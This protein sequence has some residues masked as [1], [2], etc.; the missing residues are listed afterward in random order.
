MLRVAL[1]RLYLC[2]VLVVGS[3]CK[4]LVNPLITLF[5][6]NVIF[7]VGVGIGIGIEGS[8]LLLARMA[9]KMA[10]K[11]PMPISIPTPTPNKEI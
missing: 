9:S 11:V 3:F 2:L 4:H 10:K 8:V 7:G 6:I 1:V 5:T